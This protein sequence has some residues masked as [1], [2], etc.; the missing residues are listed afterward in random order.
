MFEKNKEQEKENEVIKLSFFDTFF[1]GTERDYFLENFANLV[2]SGIGVLTALDSVRSEIRSRRLRKIIDSMR[3]D[4][5]AGSPIWRTFEKSGILPKNVIALVKIGE[6]TGRISENLKIVVSQQEKDRS[7]RSKIRSGMLYPTFVLG[8]TFIVGLGVSWFIIPRLANVFAGLHVQLPL[9]TRILITSGTLLGQY[10]YI[11]IPSLLIVLFFV[12]YFFFFFPKTKFIGEAIIFRIPGIK[13]LMIEIELARFGFVLGT[14]LKAGLPID[15][16]IASLRDV[17]SIGAYRKLYEHLLTSIDEGNSFEKS[18]N[19][20]SG[21]RQL[22]PLSVEQLVSAGEQSGNLSDIFI[23]IGSKYEDKTDTSAKNLAVILEPILLV[24]VASGVFIVALSVILPIYSLVG[25][26]S[27][28]E[29]IMQ[30][31]PPPE[32]TETVE[33]STPL[34]TPISSPEISSPES[35][36]S[37]PLEETSQPSIVSKLEILPTE[38]GY[39]RVRNQPSV[40]GDVIGRVNPGEI[41]E[42]TEELTDSDATAGAGW[43]KILLTDGGEGFVSKR[44]VKLAD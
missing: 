17:T 37:S 29:N 1:L 28:G 13:E 27:N 39:L 34:P 42:F 23:G 40:N 7:F 31:P 41:Y 10:G 32:K 11:F 12:F 4:V 26:L 24:I 2:S 8:L 18:F 35:A 3:E 16:A 22:I 25:G 33:V 9:V 21:I 20:Y 44:Y 36:S 14:L 6:Q 30:P 5:E 38:L 43:Y 15:D 19:Q